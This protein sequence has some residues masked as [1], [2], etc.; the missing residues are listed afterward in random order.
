MKTNLYKVVELDAN[1]KSLVLRDGIS[2]AEAKAMLARL[3]S[4]Y[5]QFNLRY[6]M[7]RCEIQAPKRNPY[8]DPRSRE[9]RESC[10]HTLKA[11]GF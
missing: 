8:S 10:N 7:L 9:F 3:R 6:I 11:L 1:D 5:G 4:T 2:R